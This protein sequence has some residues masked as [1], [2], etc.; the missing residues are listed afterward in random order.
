[1]NRRTFL[2]MSSLSLCAAPRPAAAQRR[3]PTQARIGVFFSGSPHT[4][5]ERTWGR[6]FVSALGDLGWREGRNLT[7]DWRYSEDR[8]DRRRA[9]VEEF[10]GLKVDVIVVQ[11]TPDACITRTMTTTNP[12]TTR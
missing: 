3:P 10:V 6:S 2:G 11:S 4:A 8:A 7:L 9:I 1:M 12:V 5:F